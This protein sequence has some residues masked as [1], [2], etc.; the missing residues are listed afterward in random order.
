MTIDEKIDFFFKSPA[1]TPAVAGIQE[2]VPNYSGEN[3]KKFST[4]YLLRRDMEKCFS[5]SPMYW[6]G[7]MAVLSGIDLMAKLYAGT[8]SGRIGDRFEKFV[9]ERMKP[10]DGAN[11]WKLRNSLMHSYGVYYEVPD[12][13]ATPVPGTPTP[14]VSK[15]F[16]LTA[17]AVPPTTGF[18]GTLFNVS[19]APDVLELDIMNLKSLFDGSI[20]SYEAHLAA[21]PA[22]KT[23]KFEG[24]F[25]KYGWIYICERMT[26]IGSCLLVDGASGGF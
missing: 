19:A 22:E 12:P 13:A 6:L 2:V 10:G 9:N 14:T 1:I 7:A 25:E 5:G 8:D 20:T 26:S 11:V 24:M 18:T 21:T 3:C 15:R 16:R 4:L 23:A 17:N